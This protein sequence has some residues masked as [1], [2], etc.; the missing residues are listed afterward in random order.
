MGILYYT[1]HLDIYTTEAPTIIKGVNDR[2]FKELALI[3]G[4]CWEVSC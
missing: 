4:Q 3:Y 2:A 1:T